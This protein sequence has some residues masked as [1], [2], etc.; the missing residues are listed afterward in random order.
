MGIPNLDADKVFFLVA[1]SNAVTS[2]YAHDRTSCP[3]GTSAVHPTEGPTTPFLRI[4]TRQLTRGPA[5]SP[6]S[7]AHVC[8][9]GG[10]DR[11]HG[12]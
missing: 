1:H 3:E 4:P 2:T 10:H 9:Q 8:V 12:G 7:F 11:R 6:L 5:L